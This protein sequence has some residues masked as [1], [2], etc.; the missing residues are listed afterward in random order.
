MESKKNDIKELIY[1]TET[2]RHKQIYGYK[3]GKMEGGI[4]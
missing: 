2:Q 1:K 4:N 3:R